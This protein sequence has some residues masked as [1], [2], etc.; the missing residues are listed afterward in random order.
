[1]GEW[2]REPSTRI[3]TSDGARSRGLES[4]SVGR[5][6]VLGHSML[7]R[8]TCST[9]SVLEPIRV[10]PNTSPYCVVHQCT[11]NTHIPSEADRHI[12]TRSS[13]C[14]SITGRNSQEPHH[15]DGSS[16]VSEPSWS[17]I[18]RRR[19]PSLR[20]ADLP[21]ITVVEVTVREFGSAASP[22][23]W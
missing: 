15:N 22:S 19:R 7:V 4:S 23:R 16:A 2:E 1:M 8:S 20:R 14:N 6:A 17:R 9:S 10:V 3:Q 13:G 21:H 11:I 12:A 18:C 5:R